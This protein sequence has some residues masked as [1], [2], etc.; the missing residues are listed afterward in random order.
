MNIIIRAAPPEALEKITA[1]QFQNLV[2]DQL[3]Q[4]G[5]LTA[6]A[7]YEAYIEAI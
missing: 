1:P 2:L 6:I 5:E 3:R 7:Q 4:M